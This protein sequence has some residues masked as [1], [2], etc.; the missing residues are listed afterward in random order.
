MTMTD[1]RQQA[2][3]AR[4]PEVA[5]ES[6]PEQ[7]AP[8]EA[9]EQRQPSEGQAGDQPTSAEKRAW[10]KSLEDAPDPIEAAR[11]LFKDIPPEQREEFARDPFFSGWIGDRA[12]SQAQKL[13]EERAE[14]RA[15]EILA[16]RERKAQEQRL[17]DAMKNEDWETLAEA[18]K[19]ELLAADELAQDGQHSQA[20]A[21][22]ITAALGD[23]VSRN[24]GEDVVNRLYQQRQK[25]EGTDYASG[26][27]AYVGDI[28]Q[29][30]VSSRER[31]LYA[32]WEK[33]RLPSLE[34]EVLARLNGEEGSPEISGG[35]PPGKRKYTIDEIR[36]MDWRDFEK[37]K[38]EIM[39][40][41][42]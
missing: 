14:K 1:E 36:R 39:S 18:K 29:E 38:A 9:P 26:L 11:R 21:G 13:A 17:R 31:E 37:N 34:K 22:H 40:L 28:A 41:I 16:D 6:T 7:S 12:K 42:T 25:Y 2:K 5:P 8:P 15:N 24:F 23:Y 35:S 30:M 3:P 32:K 10:L 4:E 33:E 20:V 19:R 27:V